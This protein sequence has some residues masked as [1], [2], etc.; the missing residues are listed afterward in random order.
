[1]IFVFL[2]ESGDFGSPFDKKADCKFNT[3]SSY[4]VLAGFAVEE[5]RLPVFE[6]RLESLKKS[7]FG[8]EKYAEYHYELRA[9]DLFSPRHILTEMRQRF[10]IAL[11]KTL[12]ELNAV[13]FATVFDKRKARSYNSQEI[14][15][16]SPRPFFYGVGY[17]RLLPQVHDFISTSFENN[18]RGVLVFD[19][20]GLDKELS[21]QIIMYLCGNKDGR[22][23]RNLAHFALYGIS[24]HI[25]CLQWADFIAGVIRYWYEYNCAPNEKLKEL[26]KAT[27]KCLDEVYSIIRKQSYYRRSDSEGEESIYG[28]QE[29]F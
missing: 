9:R 22:G 16:P 7:F 1:V 13:I 11:A 5:E 15:P 17:Q 6:R 28:F 3:N 12:Q 8:E 27:S 20:Q 21:K 4:F 18:D 19:Q 29:V 23:L 2:D 24:E 14:E 26:D 25:H 10:A